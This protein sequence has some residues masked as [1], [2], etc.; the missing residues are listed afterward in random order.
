MGVFKTLF[1]YDGNYI[2]V[3]P[4]TVI[5]NNVYGYIVWFEGWYKIVLY[6]GL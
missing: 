3:Q 2:L 4:I 5:M 1:T 6:T